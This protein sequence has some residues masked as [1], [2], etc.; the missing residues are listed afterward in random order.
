MTYQ[1]LLLRYNNII[2]Y[3]IKKIF[4][5]YMNQIHILRFILIG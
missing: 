2:I 1:K 5:Q 3:N 4:R